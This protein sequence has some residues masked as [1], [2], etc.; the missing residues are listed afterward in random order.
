[1]YFTC[2]YSLPPGA[3]FENVIRVFT[4]T[5]CKYSQIFKMNFKTVRDSGVNSAR[6]RDFKIRSVHG[7]GLDERARLLTAFWE[8]YK[9]SQDFWVGG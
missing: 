7:F 6:F 5:K 2:T 4:Q 9:G 1:M 8:G 3:K